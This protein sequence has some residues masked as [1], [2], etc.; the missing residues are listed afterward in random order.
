MGVRPPLPQNFFKIVQF[1]GN[2][3][4]K[5]PILSKFWAQG[6]PLGV[7]TPLGSPLIKILDPRLQPYHKVPVVRNTFGPPFHSLLV[8]LVSKQI[9]RRAYRGIPFV[10]HCAGSLMNEG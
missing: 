10:F 2:S 3:K 7:K 5:P 4:G 1:S 6:P 9:E 8:S